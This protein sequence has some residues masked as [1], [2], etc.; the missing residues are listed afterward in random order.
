MKESEQL[1]PGHT[2]SPEIGKR[3]SIVREYVRIGIGSAALGVFIGGTIAA[4]DIHDEKSKAY[5]FAEQI[6]PLDGPID[7]AVAFIGG[8]D[9]YTTTIAPIARGVTGAKNTIEWSTQ[10]SVE[11]NNPSVSF[12]P[13]K[14]AEMFDYDNDKE[15]LACFNDRELSRLN[16]S[17]RE[18][19]NLKPR[20]YLYTI[21]GDIKTCHSSDLP[22][23]MRSQAVAT[24]NGSDV[25]YNLY[26]F[27][28]S[29]ANIQAD[30][31]TA[32]LTHETGHLLGLHH[33]A[34]LTNNGG[35]Q[36]KSEDEYGLNQPGNI[37]QSIQSM[38]DTDNFRPRRYDDDSGVINQYAYKGSI[39]GGGGAYESG[40]KQ[41]FLP[42]ELNQIDPDKF[43]LIH[44][45]P[46][47][48]TEPIDLSYIKPYSVGIKIDVKQGDTLKKIDPT[49]DNLVIGIRQNMNDELFQYDNQVAP[50]DIAVVAE[51]KDLN[52]VIASQ[53]AKSPTVDQP[54]IVYMDEAQD[55]VVVSGIR[56][57]P[58]TGDYVQSLK[59]GT[60]AQTIDLRH[61]LDEKH[62]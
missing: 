15:A 57:N 21:L 4:Y 5:V 27:D 9:D 25:A 47:V 55:I 46:G 49:I 28:P 44:I 60:Y 56:H 32:V 58:T 53:Q 40:R 10:R 24:L 38:I 7:T 31:I 3:Q 13:E 29:K 17:I 61:T 50:L 26:P 19:L 20:T 45:T 2:A 39:M 54:Q 59:V 23:G 12:Y 41:A 35:T 43:T 34:V 51:G 8:P 37:T 62:S 14:K 11:L 48:D 52:Y 33:D 22:N 30:D 1:Q 18:R 36:P 6:D 42:G 16:Q